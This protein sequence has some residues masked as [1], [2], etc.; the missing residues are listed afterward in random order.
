MLT[1]VEKDA[2]YFAE[3]LK[4]DIFVPG[5]LPDYTYRDNAHIWHLNDGKGTIAM[6]GSKSER[7]TDL[8]R[9][10]DALNVEFSRDGMREASLRIKNL[11]KGTNCLPM[12]GRIGVT[13]HLAQGGVSYSLS[14]FDEVEEIKETNY[15]KE[16]ES[17]GSIVYECCKDISDITERIKTYY[18]QLEKLTLRQYFPIALISTRNDSYTLIQR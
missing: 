10:S 8:I 18:T 15:L 1:I 9:Y 6:I 5:A 7:A 12:E 14:E 4:Y 17:K 3:P 2:V 11:L 13:L 16:N